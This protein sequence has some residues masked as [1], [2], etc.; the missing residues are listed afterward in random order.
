MHTSILHPIT[1]AYLAPAI[2]RIRFC[3]H[4]DARF[5][6][7]RLS[8]RAYGPAREE[9]ECGM[10]VD[11]GI[12]DAGHDSSSWDGASQDT[13]ATHTEA[14]G[15]RE[16]DLPDPR[17]LAQD[18]ITLWQSEISAMAADPEMRESWQTMMALWAGIMSTM[19]RVMPRAT[20][21]HERA[22]G[23]PRTTDAP[24][25]PSAAA[26]PDTRDVEIERLA[27]HV[28]ILERRLADLERGGDPP[29]HPKRR[30]TRKPRK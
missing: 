18:W 8:G 25:T 4:T 15:P 24:R 17:K 23:Q 2:E 20:E 11:A 3:F 26:A 30:P 12:D 28:A 14:R 22:G 5:V 13:G 21:R 16:S 29:V 6:V 27:R 9:D 10:V 1:T 19:V 7:S